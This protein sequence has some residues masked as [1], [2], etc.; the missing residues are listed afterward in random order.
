MRARVLQGSVCRFR[1]GFRFRFRLDA[2]YTPAWH[3]IAVEVFPPRGRRIEKR[4]YS[5]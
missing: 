5:H 1:F 4:Q 2:W 3:S